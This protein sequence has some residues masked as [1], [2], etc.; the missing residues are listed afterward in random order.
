M[1]LP[2]KSKIPSAHIEGVWGCLSEFL[3]SPPK[4]K[5]ALIWAWS[6]LFLNSKRDHKLLV[7]TQKN[8]LFMRM[9]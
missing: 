8:A 5:R 4:T 6:K 2:Q 7:K 3:S 9:E 1:V